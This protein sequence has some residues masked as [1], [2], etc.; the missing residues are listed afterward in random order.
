MRTA[1]GQHETLANDLP[2]DVERS[3]KT[4]LAV[5]LV[6]KGRKPEA[7]LMADTVCVQ[8]ASQTLTEMWDYLK[9]SGVCP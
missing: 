3:V 4:M 8:P 7:R 1:L 6:I 9:E 2:P 5:V